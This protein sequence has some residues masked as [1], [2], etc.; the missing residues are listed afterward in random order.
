VRDG[1]C[2]SMVR[3]NKNVIDS[4]EWKNALDGLQDK[5]ILAADLQKLLR[6]LLAG[7]GPE[8]CAGTTGH[9]DCVH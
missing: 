5:R 4:Y 1:F 3:N 9:D 2:E 7:Q 6:H 8:P